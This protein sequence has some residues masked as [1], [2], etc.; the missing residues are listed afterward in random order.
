MKLFK[1]NKLGKKIASFVAVAALASM[2][3]F[4]TLGMHADGPRFNFLEGDWEL[5]AGVNTSKSETVWKDPVSASDGETIEGL[6]YY[7]N[8][9]VNTVAENTRV[10]VTLPSSAQNNAVVATAKISAD[11]AQTITDTIVNGKIIGKS[12]LTINLDQEAELEYIPNSVKWYPNSQSSP[13]TPVA[14]PFGQNGSELFSANGLRLGDINGCWEYAGFVK[15]ALKV[16]APVKNSDI[17]IQKTVKKTNSNDV[18]SESASIAMG[19][20]ATFKIDVTNNGQT[21]LDSVIIKDALPERLF[22]IS[23]SAKMNRASI[24][25][26]I[27]IMQLISKGIIVKDL[28]IQESLEITF[29][30]SGGV[31]TLEEESITNTATATYGELI[32]SDKANL[33][34]LAGKTDIVKSK[35]AYN[36]TQKINATI[37]PARSND[38]IE[39]S[40]TVKNNGNIASIYT[41]DDGVADVLEYADIVSIADMGQLVEGEGT[42]NFSKIIRFPSTL[43]APESEII[44]TFTVRIKNQLPNNPQNGFSYDYKMYNKYGNE[45]IVEVEKPLPP[46]LKPAL[47]IEKF[48]RNISANQLEYT[49]ANTAYAGDVLEYKIVFK[50]SGEAPADYIK[51]WDALPSNVSIDNNAAAILGM[52]NAERSI[53]ENM[54]YG[55]IISTLA[56]GKEGYIRFRVI[57]SEQIASDEILK[58]T[59][60]LDDDGVTIS[61]YAETVIK[62]KIVPAKATPALPRTGSEGSILF[63]IITS[64]LMTGSIVFAYERTRR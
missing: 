5:L 36:K 58:N 31:H 27:D 6:I 16:K 59:A 47:S 39:Y 55:Y 60:Y 17:S 54:S 56:P 64:L 20:N 45:V 8:G 51:V 22:P 7:H 50:N 46:V 9:N 48:V 37:S 32:R 4:P 41:I 42:G 18:Y 21:N 10:T 23:G 19:E 28:E 38:V 2:A 26:D 29:N 43:V 63:S 34:L 52:D 15:F 57:T 44:R 53:A 33:V 30:V 24:E 14:L 11:N 3:I 40:L 35:S 12:G 1:L 61:S 49:K 13:N 62:Q 25:T